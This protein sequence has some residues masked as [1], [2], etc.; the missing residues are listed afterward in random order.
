MI[1]A[2]TKERIARLKQ[3]FDSI[4]E[5][6]AALLRLL[7]EKEIPEQ[8]Y[9]SNAIENSTLTLEQTEGIIYEGRT[10]K[11]AS[12]R[13]V[14]EAKNL[15]N[16]LDFLEAHPHYE[17]TEEHILEL[18][19]MLIGGI[20]NRIAGRFRDWGEE[21]RVGRHIAPAP[22]HVE[23][24]VEDIIF[25]YEHEKNEYFLDKIAKFHARFEYIHPFN[26]GNGRTGRIL[27]NLQLRELGY[28]PIT[29]REKNR[30]KEYYALFR[31]YQTTRK[32]DGFTELF[33]V[34]LCES[35]HKRLAYA[36]RKEIVKL[37]DWAREHG[38]ELNSL[39]NAAKRQTI[40]AFR[41]RGS[42]M[43]AG[44]WKEVNEN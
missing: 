30:D 11:D 42:W 6:R 17:V 38:K 9:N 14:Y 4:R 2:I 34:L 41:E 31:E 10:P 37:A 33:A 16:V 20:S 36:R 26:D 8:V 7:T 3:E 21:V 43:I 12:V 19:K 1:N 35:L 5:E 39:L 23:R 28:P 29:I 44:D 15:A 40:P 32:Y 22:E 27:M 24:M 25:N 13:E 18:H